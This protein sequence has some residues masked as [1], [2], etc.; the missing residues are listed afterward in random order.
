MSSD[1]RIV[2]QAI[3]LSWL[4]GL[5]M[6][7]RPQP[8]PP[9][10]ARR[11]TNTGR[12]LSQFFWRYLRWLGDASGKYNVVETHKSGDG[13]IVRYTLR[14]EDQKF[15]NDLSLVIHAPAFY[16]SMAG[17]ESLTDFLQAALLD[18]Y[19]E[20]RTASCSRTPKDLMDLLGPAHSQLQL[21]GSSLEPQG[22]LTTVL[23]KATAAFPCQ[24]AIPVYPQGDPKVRTRAETGMLKQ[25]T[26]LQGMFLLPFVH[27]ACTAEMQWQFCVT[28][29]K[30]SAWQ[31]L[32]KLKH[33]FRKERIS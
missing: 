4:R 6:W 10:I 15:C 31:W 14:P 20:N 7:H 8:R 19:E 1:G 18:T 27:S 24:R 5:Q 13:Y 25:G 12:T 16:S 29:L 9:S 22:P 11:A 33:R 26:F 17:C 30:I 23:F 28:L 21:V 3:K 32:R 2:I